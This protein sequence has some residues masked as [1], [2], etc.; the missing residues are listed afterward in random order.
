[1]NLLLATPLPDADQL[2]NELW[3]EMFKPEYILKYD[4]MGLIIYWI[5][6]P[7]KGLGNTSASLIEILLWFLLLIALSL[8]AWWGW[9]TWR[10]RKK[11]TEPK[12]EQLLIDP[13]ISAAEYQ[14]KA[15]QLRE[16]NPDEA[17]K[18]AFRSGVA[19]L[20]RAEI[21][22]VTPGSTAGEAALIMRRN[23]PDLAET[24]DLAALLFNTA[25]YSLTPAPRTTPNDVNTVLILAD[26]LRTRVEATATAAN[27][28]A[29]S[30]PA[31]QWEVSL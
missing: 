8:L 13:K 28:Q 17:V 10:P 2:Q 26:A 25:A 30:T 27:V 14:Q 20:D 11:I 24:I 18:N 16:T 29:G 5:T 7:L 3:W 21:M 1:M 12:A 4:W 22:S 6:K 23:F 9:R 31:P 19:T 15:L